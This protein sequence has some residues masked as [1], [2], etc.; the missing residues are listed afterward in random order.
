MSRT[1]GLSRFLGVAL[2]ALGLSAC[3][4]SSPGILGGGSDDLSALAKLP[5]AGKFTVA[6]YNVENLFD[7]SNTA[8]GPS[9]PAK[10]DESKQHLAESIRAL[11]ADVLGL[12]EVESRA[13]L[14]HFRDDYL[15]D[16][17]YQYIALQ[18]G[19]DMRGIDVAVLSRF[20][21]THLK[22]HRN[23]VFG[24]PGAPAPGKLSRDLLQAKIAVGKGYSFTLFVTHL[25]ARPGEPAS[26][27]KRKAEAQFIRR[28]LRDFESEH[29]NANYALVGDFNDRPTSETLKV[30]LE[31]RDRDP[32]LF[33]ALSE[34]GTGA[35][36]YHPIKYRGRIDYIL[37]SEGIRKEYIPNSA[38]ILNIPAALKASD[39]LPGSIVIDGSLDR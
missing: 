30:F 19:N 7:G 15:K 14:R 29:P 18:E 16:M 2:L 8:L 28:T 26:D 39:H 20:P 23:A 33:D 9:N 34:L 25:K 12:V 4:L 24:V 22:S 1:N 13:T 3:G 37:L 35:Y 32:V 5:P 10:S 31:G 36:S 27:A 17:G 21:I 6:T 11:N 38:Q